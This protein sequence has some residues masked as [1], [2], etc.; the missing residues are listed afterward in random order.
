TTDL[1]ARI[2]AQKFSEG[3][4]QQVIVDNRAGA[5]TT[6]GT[7]FVARAAPDGY[8]LL[9]NSASIITTVPLYP[10]LPYDPI[11]DFIPIGPVG[12]SF[13]VM[14]VHP[15]MPT[16][17]VKEFIALAKAKPRQITYASAG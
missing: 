15:S 16:R 4:G 8:T 17:T 9:F 6:L 2:V 5:A 11:K 10:N 13:Y 12:Q 1:V 3:L 7:G 14:A